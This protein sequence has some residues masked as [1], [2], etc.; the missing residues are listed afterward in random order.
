MSNNM[1][2][3][4][5]E[6][7]CSV[8]GHTFSLQYHSDGTYTYLSGPCDCEAEFHPLGPSLSEWLEQI[9][10]GHRYYDK[11]GK[12][13]KA[14][15]TLRHN[16]GDTEKVHE[17]SDS[18]GIA[19]L[20]FQAS[21]PWF[22]KLHPEWAIEYYPLSQFKLSEWEIVEPAA[23]YSDPTGIVHCGHCHTELYCTD[24][25][26]MPKTCP[27]CKKELSWGVFKPNCIY[28]VSIHTDAYKPRR[29]SKKN[30][31]PGTMNDYMAAIN[32]WNTIEHSLKE[33]EW[34]LYLF[35]GNNHLISEWVEEK[36]DYSDEYKAWLQQ[37]CNIITY[38]DKLCG[39]ERTQ[40]TSGYGYMQGY[41]RVAKVLA[42]LEEN[43]TVKIP[44]KWLYDTRQYC[45][46]MDGC[47]MQ[48]TKE[49]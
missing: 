40:L 13:I 7:Q 2:H 28:K 47:Y 36:A 48:I 23:V 26:D 9:R 38:L 31:E 43:G 3:K 42:E 39:L 10:A 8:C 41:F 6:Q 22:V 20:G 24:T 32:G 45:K 27:G 29:C 1:K 11:F 49:G 33:V 44:F 21:N 12:E 35:Q 25:G 46:N 37:P 34:R 4:I 14:G 5:V 30:W 17:C 15:M 16:C 19:D 18:S